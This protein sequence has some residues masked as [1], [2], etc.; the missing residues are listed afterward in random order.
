[1]TGKYI[2]E[3]DIN[4]KEKEEKKEEIDISGFDIEEI[5]K[6]Q[7]NIVSK[8]INYNENLHENK[9]F[10]ENI[11]DTYKRLSKIQNIE[12]SISAEN[13]EEDYDEELSE[14]DLSLKYCEKNLRCALNI[15]QNDPNLIINR[16][17]I[18]KLNRITLNNII[19]FN[20]IIGDIY[21][22]LMNKE[23]LFNYDNEEFEINDLIIFINKLIQF[24]ELEI[25]HNTKLGIN[26]INSL[27]KFLL[28]ISKEF[29]LE[30]LQLNSIHDILYV[31][32]EISH[33]KLSKVPFKSF[34]ISLYQELE[35]Q[36]NIYEQYKIFLQ[37]KNYI[38]FFIGKWDEK[39][40]DCHDNFLTLGKYFIY[41]FFNKEFTI[42]LDK[43]N[44]NDVE[45]ERHLIFD[46]RENKKNMKVINGKRFRIYDDDEVINELREG[47]CEIIL[48]YIEKF[49]A[50]FYY[51][52]V[53]YI[54]YMLIKRIYFSNYM[55]YKKRV[56][57]ILVDSLINMCYFK[58]APLKM[59][60]HFINK[61]LKSNVEDE[62]ELK[63]ILIENLTL[64]KKEK[65][66]LYKFPKF[67]SKFE[68][69]NDEIQSEDE[70]KELNQE[71]NEEEETEEEDDI[72]EEDKGYS[73]IKDEILFMYHN[74]LNIGFLNKQIINA[75]QKFI[76]YEVLNE[77]FS[78]LDFC[79]K[80]EDYD[81]KL[82]IT[83][84]N[85]DRIIYSKERLNSAYESPLKLIMFFTNQKILKFEIDNTYSWFRKKIINYKSN[86]FYPKYPYS[87][88]H[89]LLVDKYRKNILKYKNNKKKKNAKNLKNKKIVN[90]DESDK[91]LI[92]KSDGENKVLNCINVKQNLEAINRMVEDKYLYVSSMFI[93]LKN[94]ENLENINNKKNNKR[95]SYFYYYKEND[96]LVETEL[97]KESMENYLIN[98]LPKFNGAINIINLYI[99]NG[100]FNAE[101]NN[102]SLKRILG[103]DPLI[104]LDGSFQK[105]LYF[106]QILSQAQLYYYLYQQIYNQNSI[107]MIIL[108]NYTK[109]GGY[110][111]STFINDEIESNSEDFKG[112][113]KNESID[114]NIKIICECIKKLDRKFR[115][116]DIVLTASVD[117]KESEITCEK[118]EE[119]ILENL[120]NYNSDKK[121]IRIIKTDMEFNIDL[122][123]NSH[124][125]YLDN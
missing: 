93:K 87:I 28:I 62:L 21:I 91:I 104:K 26:Y 123:K 53:Q 2:L 81:I 3:E 9:F 124:I 92:I 56:N 48:K 8:N 13:E 76:F 94:P 84:V 108:I 74:D 83:D 97:T 102:Y 64:A 79:L 54:I 33:I 110:Q 121:N 6:K 10:E 66:F 67:F 101:N 38:M 88:S 125:F 106:V 17:V 19:T 118:L 60:S 22:S 43:N 119:K 18:D 35:S 5:P 55:Q 99:I 109:Y 115:T 71:K 45:G 46:G 82:T 113:N 120:Q 70:K 36:P 73:V 4:K 69:K 105:I 75:G 42:Y 29:D 24:K 77:E 114:N 39:D 98:Q 23:S 61:I 59:I 72:S 86:I 103:F 32:K 122:Q 111:V 80:L 58:E 31:N 44:E 68:I 52:D 57:N 30:E 107:D 78:V 16:N 34:L 47:L 41:L 116:I 49:I 20:F 51:Y 89:E 112:L 117:D 40:P 95:K 27:R 85:E 63:N 37:N 15:C 100:D 1:M 11:I 14:I 25:M 7:N 12:S 90:S 96:G 65:N 50:M